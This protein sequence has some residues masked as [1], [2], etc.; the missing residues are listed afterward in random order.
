[1]KKL[2]TILLFWGVSGNAI[3]QNVVLINP[4]DV[5]KGQEAAAI[6]YWEKARDFLKNQPGYVSTKLHQTQNPKAR[7]HIINVA[8]WKSPKDFKVAIQKMNKELEPAKIEGLKFYPSLYKVIR[9]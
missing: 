1:M 9:E 5:P 3:S 6:A 2:L 8:E 4:F 7:F